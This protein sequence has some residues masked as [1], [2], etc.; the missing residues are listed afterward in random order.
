MRRIDADAIK[1]EITKYHAGLKPRYISKLVDAEIA[2][3][4]DII[5]ESP[6]VDAEPVRYGRW[7]RNPD[8]VNAFFCSLCGCWNGVWW[9]EFA[10]C[11]LKFCPWCGA[12]MVG[13]AEK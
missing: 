10:E 13:G 5:D 6:T 7:I 1:H 2:D 11:T 3:I 12:K 4:Q 9:N 8:D